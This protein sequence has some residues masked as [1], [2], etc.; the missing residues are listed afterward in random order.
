MRAIIIAVGSEMLE[1]GRIDTNSI[2]ITEKLMERG[3]LVDMK[4]VVG[5]DLEN[6]TWAIKNAHKRTNLVII[7]GGLGPTEDD[8]TREAVANALKREME[9]KPEL[10]EHI[11][12]IFRKRGIPMPEINTRQA[13]VVQGFE[14]VPN[15]NG[16]AAGQFLNEEPCRL[17][18]LPGP[19]NEMKAMFDKVLEEKIAPLC[20]FF[21]YKRSFKF[22]GESES[23]VD[24]KIAELY[25]KY[26][27]PKT[28]ILAAPGLIEVHLLGRSKKTIE[29]AKTLTDELAEKIKER[30]KDSLVTEKDITFP[31]YI[32]EELKSK[33]LTLSVAESCTGG[34]LGHA[35]TN[36]PGSSEVFLG[37]VIAYSNE[38]KKKLLN[39]GEHTLNRHGAVSRE[40][41]KEMA[42]GVR[43]LTGSDIGI[44]ITGIAGPTG[45]TYNKP[46]GLV[47][48]HLSTKDKEIAV[49]QIFPGSR[50]IVKTR[51]I[52]TAL[53]LI[54]T[55]L[56]D[57]QLS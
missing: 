21:I 32:I 40:T 43:L 46:V 2:Y 19:P 13:F 41:A 11:E 7:T 30:M 17:L 52:N 5:D 24:S 33:K 27:N 42:E 12:T 54:R 51:T 34:G 4:M 50:D 56:K 44:S 53:N 10:K 48:V 31:E 3:V 35:I 36:V 37:G 6:L 47:F 18:M 26:K 57:F 23:A 8:L 1:I 45:E 22:G 49:H 16:T 38:L 9:F 20:H 15:P 55:F 25:V 39:V 29:E 28:T 14:V